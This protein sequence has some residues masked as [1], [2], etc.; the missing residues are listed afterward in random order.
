ML[1][2]WETNTVLIS[3]LL[4]Q[5]HRE[6][7]RQLETTLAE[8]EIP[9]MIVPGT[10]DIWIRDAAPIQ[11]DERRFTQF[12]YTPNYL[13]NGYE[14][15]IT[16]P[17]VFRKLKLSQRSKRS[18]LIVDG[19]NIVGTR[20]VAI[21]TDKVFTE[22]SDRS[23]SEIRD[24]LQRGLQIERIIVIPKEPFDR[25]GHAD[26]MVRF[27]TENQ[28][29]IS[30]YRSVD[31]RL[32]ERLEEVLSAN[33]LPFVRLPYV[34]ES[35]LRGGIPSA[36]GNYVNFLRVGNV[37]LVPAY[38]LP[39]DNVAGDI[40]TNLLPHCRVAPLSC[41]TLAEEGGVLNCASWTI[42]KSSNKHN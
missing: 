24:E 8:H 15:L 6:L 22:N 2:D 35:R 34:P 41:R 18:K 25:V 30:D 20:F 1:A 3:D 27:V 5:R 33:A 13:R 4:S 29:V 26:G 9:L 38:G 28:V 40:L 12:C 7:S 10:A 11:V 21:V 16:R 23:R 32:A 36:V 31:P 37:I 19:G 39:E 17:E 42:Q 14:H